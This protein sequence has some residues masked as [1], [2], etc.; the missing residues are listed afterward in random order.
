MRELQARMGLTEQGGRNNA[1]ALEGLSRAIGA[2]LDL[3]GQQTT[4]EIAGANIGFGREQLAEQGRQFNL[5]FELDQ[6]RRDMELAEQRS[7]LN[8]I[9]K[10]SQ[11]GVNL[12]RAA[13]GGISAYNAITGR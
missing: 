13:G 3:T 2:G 6:Q 7:W 5:N 1:M 8:K 10:A 11:A 12:A 9:L 4:R